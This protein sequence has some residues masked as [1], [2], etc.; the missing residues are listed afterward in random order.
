MTSEHHLNTSRRLKSK[1]PPTTP[2]S[3]RTL[4]ASDKR[5]VYRTI[6]SIHCGRNSLNNMWPLPVLEAVHDTA[7]PCMECTP[8]D[9]QRYEFEISIGECIHPYTSKP[10]EKRFW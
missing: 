3:F 8:E 10:V 4:I 5:T 9:Q 6:K 1:G 2:N 7:V